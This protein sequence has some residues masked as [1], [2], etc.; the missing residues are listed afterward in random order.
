MALGAQ[1]QLNLDAE[2]ANMNGQTR[3][4]PVN[5]IALMFLSFTLG[6]T[7][8]DD[9]AASG[10]DTGTI[11]ACASGTGC[12][13]AEDLPYGLLSVQARATDD[14]WIVGS[15]PEPADG[16][17]PAI[18]Q[19]DGSDWRRLDTTAHAGAELWWAWIHDDEA[20]FVGNQGLIVELDREGDEMVA[21]DGPVATTTFFGVWGAGPEDLWAVGMTE[22]GDGPWAL[23]RRLDGEWT[24]W[25]DPELGAGEAGVT[26]FKVHGTA[27]DDVWFVGTGGLSLRWNGSVLQT[28]A[29]DADVPT[30][31]AP[32]LTVD[33]DPAQPVA[34]GGAGNG[35]LLEY[36]GSAWRDKSPAFQPG[37][38]GVCSGAGQQWAVGQN[39]SRSQRTAEGTW[40]SDTDRMLGPPTYQ[41][42]HG[43]D[44][45]P[46][47]T[48]WTVGGR[49]ASRPLTS[50]VIGVQGPGTPS[51][52]PW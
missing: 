38:N 27:A 9:T 10:D 25:T 6:C 7:K 33:A 31:T 44:V 39:G 20:V 35:L 47:G 51:P 50:G 23:W 34:V 22:D 17:G 30:A 45:D 41:D 46:G 32:L 36:D 24:A 43:C 19:Y 28:I 2:S 49:I 1:I 16:T 29:T 26:L 13:L 3:K 37:L 48:L 40:A 11:G 4:P 52:L 21:V 14:V 15:S 5:P 18:L 42:W 12:L 8:G